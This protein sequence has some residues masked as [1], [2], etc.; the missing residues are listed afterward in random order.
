MNDKQ[1]SVIETDKDKLKE[2]DTLITKLNQE[3]KSLTGENQRIM[4]EFTCRDK[5]NKISM[6]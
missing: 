3:I 6:E 4:Q 2:K 1:K 5:A